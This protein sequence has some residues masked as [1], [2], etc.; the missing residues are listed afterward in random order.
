MTQVFERGTRTGKDYYKMLG[1]PR[2]A[3]EK[4]IK[5]AYRKLA[6]KYHPDVNP[7]NPEAEAKFKEVS[8]AYEV[9]SN[10]EKRAKYDQFGEN[11]ESFGGMGTGGGNPYGGIGGSGFETIFEQIFDTFGGGAGFGGMRARQIPPVDIEQSL[12]VSLREIDSGTRRSLTYEVQDACETCGGAGTVMMTTQQITTCPRCQGQGTQRRQRKVDVTVPQGMESG[13]KLR[14]SGGGGKGS[15]GRAGDLYVMVTVPE[16]PIFRR[17]GHDLEVDL[18]VDYLAAALGGEAKVP[19]LEGSV[20]ARIPAGSQSGQVLRL[21]EKGLHGPGKSV[22][23]L[24]ARIR[25]TVPKDLSEKEKELLA[26]V[27]KQRE[28]QS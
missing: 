3:D 16:D 28:A 24:H 12:S 2:G 22:G 4:E 7:N 21:R 1:V 14:V 10:P 19:T 15:N 5:A 17:K 27:Q 11:W 8:E 26:Q 9:L 20:I 13:K 23:D 25:I 18:P 6:R